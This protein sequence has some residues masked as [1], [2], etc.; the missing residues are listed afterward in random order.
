VRN[1]WLRASLGLRVFGVICRA[2]GPAGSQARRSGSRFHSK[3]PSGGLF[4]TQRCH[5]PQ[6]QFR[7]HDRPRHR[8][9]TTTSCGSG[10]R[11]TTIPQIE[12]TWR[13]RGRRCRRPGWRTPRMPPARACPAARR[14]PTS[15]TRRLQ[16][17]GQRVPDDAVVQV[18]VQGASL[19]AGGAG[20]GVLPVSDGCRRSEGQRLPQRGD[21]GD[22]RAKLSRRF[23]R[24]SAGSRARPGLRG[25]GSRRRGPEVAVV[26]WKFLVLQQ[27]ALC[28]PQLRVA[29]IV[30]APHDSTGPV[31]LPRHRRLP[32]DCS[33]EG[34]SGRP[35]DLF[36]AGSLIRL[37]VDRQTY[38]VPRS[39][40]QR[41]NDGP[42]SRHGRLP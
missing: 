8:W 16:P 5:G 12:H 7:N 10:A 36:K 25:R 9:P 37:E 2:P 24:L 18:Q 4:A 38:Y 6:A 21:R 17:G 1:R 3:V 15:P 11:R 13:Q 29:Q 23:C 30:V 34:G 20:G 33:A 40:V 41:N 35:P 31:R 39:I 22:R 26:P 27:V 19:D 14:D 42:I 28:S 32:P